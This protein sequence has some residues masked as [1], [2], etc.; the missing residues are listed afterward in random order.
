MR[1]RLIHLAEGDVDAAAEEFVHFAAPARANPLVGGV[2]IGWGPVKA[3]GVGGAGIEEGFDHVG[4]LVG[5][6][7]SQRP[8]FWVLVEA[9]QDALLVAIAE[10]GYSR[11]WLAPFGGG[12]SRLVAGE[13]GH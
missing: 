2:R 1:S 5:Y 8:L 10:A 4:V 13:G 7:K 11:F 12:V 3:G 6:V 9:E